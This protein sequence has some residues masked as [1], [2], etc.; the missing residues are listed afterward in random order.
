MVLNILIQVSFL[1]VV[2]VINK[3]LINTLKQRS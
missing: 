3:Q 1:F 2:V